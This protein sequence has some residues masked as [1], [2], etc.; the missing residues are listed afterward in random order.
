M[1]K[2]SVSYPSLYNK[3]VFITGGTSGI[4]SSLVEH[5]LAEGAWIN[6]I[7][8]DDKNADGLISI[9]DGHVTYKSCNAFDIN[10]IPIAI[11]EFEKSMGGSIDILGKM[12]AEM[13]VTA[14]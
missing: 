4:G 11:S 6:F 7:D 2:N 8:I 3:S 9:L 12:G 13:I 1:R 14:R 10:A 5:F